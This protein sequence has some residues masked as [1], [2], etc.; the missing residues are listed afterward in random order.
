M[1]KGKKILIAISAS[2]AAYK[3]PLLVRMLV[4]EGAEV[5]VIMTSA[6]QQF[7][8]SLTLATLSKRPVF[9]EFV[10]NELGEWNNHVELGLWADIMLIAPASAHTLS[11]CANGICNDL[12][13]AVYLSAKCPVYFAPAMDLDMYK[14]P[15]T[16]LNISKLKSYGN[17]IIAPNSGELASGLVGE[18][19][20]AEPEEMLE[21]IQ[22]FFE[23]NQK[24][25]G[26]NVLITAGPTQ[27][28]IDPVRFISNHSTGKMGYA[29]AN[30][31]A[32]MGANV[33]LVSGPVANLQLENNVK[34]ISVKS[35]QNMFEATEQ[36]FIDSDIVVLAAAVADYTPK[37]VASTKIKKSEQTFNIELTKTIDIAKTL[38]NIKTTQFT[39]GFALETNNEK[40]NALTKLTSKNLDMIIL[41]SLQDTGAGFGHDTNKITIFNKN[42]TQI[43][44][45]LKSKKQVAVDIVDEICK[46]FA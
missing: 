2:I 44:F 38:G 22:S 36:Y 33:T 4:K 17:T 30:R 7:V 42:G 11:K 1:L 6:T 32:Q 25:L 23:E 43:D 28:S 3:I 16:L 46:H 19:R 40:E 20:M 12:L 13:S 39:V 34:L 21:V 41:N 15:S 31:F 18:G 10:N 14:H 5:Q 35:A 45:D 29:I 37:H 8:T 24:L 27:E 26:K 9:T